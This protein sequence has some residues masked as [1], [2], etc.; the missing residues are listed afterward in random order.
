MLALAAV[1]LLVLRTAPMLADHHE[2]ALGAMAVLLVLLPL[3]S[4]VRRHARRTADR[5]RTAHELRHGR[6]L[7]AVAA[8]TSL[9]GVTA[10]VLVVVLP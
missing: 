1:L 9:L 7:A 2:L 3:G 10:L 5:F 6:M 4:L 8:A